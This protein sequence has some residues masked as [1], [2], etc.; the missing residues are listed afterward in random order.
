MGLPCL[1]LPAKMRCIPSYP[2]RVVPCVLLPARAL[3]VRQIYTLGGARVKCFDLGILW[4][5]KDTQSFCL[6]NSLRCVK[7]LSAELWRFRE[8]FHF[9]LDFP[10]SRDFRENL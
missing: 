2:A 10:L 9:P 1:D 5:M 6:T 4:N 7:I 8:F 3:N